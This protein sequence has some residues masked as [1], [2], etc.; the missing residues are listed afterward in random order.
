MSAW[1]I[2]LVA[3]RPFLPGQLIEASLD[4]PGLYHDVERMCLVVVSRVVRSESNRTALQVLRHEFRQ[5]Q[6]VQR[7]KPMRGVGVHTAA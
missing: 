6:G 5:V 3:D 1:G 7:S 2:L 4:W